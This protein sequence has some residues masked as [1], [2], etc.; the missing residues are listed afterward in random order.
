MS[1][2]TDDRKLKILL[3]V[4]LALLA[5]L[6][7]VSALVNDVDSPFLIVAD[8]SPYI[9]AFAAVW[10]LASFTDGKILEKVIVTAASLALL[11]E[12]GTGMMQIF[13]KASSGNLYYNPFNFI[14]PALCKSKRP[15]AV[16]AGLLAIATVAPSGISLT[17]LYLSEYKPIGSK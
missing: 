17:L 15:R 10:A 6:E 13:G 9:L 14:N 5:G 12:C 1:I 3:L 7:A 16:F 8:L 11:Y 4:S 2:Q